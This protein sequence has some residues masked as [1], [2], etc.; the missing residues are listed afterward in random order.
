LESTHSDAVAELPSTAAESV[1]GG[2][3]VV[4]ANVAAAD[5]NDWDA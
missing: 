2:N 3:G 5:M 1:V 4:G